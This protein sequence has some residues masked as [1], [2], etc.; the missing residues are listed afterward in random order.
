MI[1]VSDRIALR[2]DPIRSWSNGT[3]QT[4][5]SQFFFFRH[6]VRLQPTGSIRGQAGAQSRGRSVWSPP[7]HARG[8]LWVPAF[9]SLSR[10]CRRISGGTICQNCTTRNGA[11]ISRYS[12]VIG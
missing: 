4:D 2:F 3:K 12:R 9:A 7:V 11:A 10:E 5:G 8:K 1:H 6:P